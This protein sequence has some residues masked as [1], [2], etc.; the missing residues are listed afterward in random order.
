LEISASGEGP[1]KRADE[2][3]ALLIEAM[4]RLGKI[5]MEQWASGAENTLSEQLPQ[6]D[7]SAVVHKKKR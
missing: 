5:T 4:R 6:K 3:E 7:P 1:L 2:I